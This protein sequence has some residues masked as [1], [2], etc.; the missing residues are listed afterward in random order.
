[1]EERWFHIVISTYG[2]WLH[3]D[4]RG[5]R[6]RHHREHVEGDYKNPPAPGQH[7][8]KF[9]RSKKLLKQP[10]VI[11]PV[12]FRLIIGEAVRDRLTALGT[13]VLTISCGGQHCHIQAK[14][15]EQFPREWAGLAKKYAWFIARDNG[16]VGRI[17][18]K[19]S[20]ATPI[21]DRQ[22]QVN[23]YGYVLDHIHEGAWVWSALTGAQ[24]PPVATGGL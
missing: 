2:S 14:M 23:V 11:I 8:W 12:N 15:G 21:N 10:P 7:E 16:W 13:Y 9:E 19:R 1:M 6:T 3:G 18:A 4:P 20:K 5:F 17:W 24:C 22:H